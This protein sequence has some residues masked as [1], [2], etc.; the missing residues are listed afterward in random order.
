MHIHICNLLILWWPKVHHD[1]H[2]HKTIARVR[3]RLVMQKQIQSIVYIFIPCKFELLDVIICFRMLGYLCERVAFLTLQS[4]RVYI[5]FFYFY[6]FFQL[7]VNLEQK[8][9]VSYVKSGKWFVPTPSGFEPPHE[10]LHDRL[11]CVYIERERIRKSYACHIL[12]VLRSK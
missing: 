3:H 9:Y 5:S 2:S 4:K 11:Q 6:F 7:N 12:R 10:H 8:Q 1:Q